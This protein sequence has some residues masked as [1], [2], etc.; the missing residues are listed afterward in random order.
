MNDR[1]AWSL[2]FF[3]FFFF[4]PETVQVGVVGRLGI[5]VFTWQ[6]FDKQRNSFVKRNIDTIM[7]ELYSR[8]QYPNSAN[9][10]LGS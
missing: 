2:F 6:H 7:Y 9:T 3:L 10:Y 1:A 5:K 4:F 8:Y